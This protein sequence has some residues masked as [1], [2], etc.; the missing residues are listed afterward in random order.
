[1]FPEGKTLVRDSDRKV[2]TIIDAGFWHKIRAADGEEDDV[3]WHAEQDFVS[4][5]RG[6]GYRTTPDWSV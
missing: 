6:H 2:F 3:K 5:N 4:A 1:M